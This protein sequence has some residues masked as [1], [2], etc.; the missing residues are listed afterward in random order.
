MW[1]EVWTTRPTDSLPT[2]SA[3]R[4]VVSVGGHDAQTGSGAG[5]H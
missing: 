2:G 3:H 5:F 4:S 1:L